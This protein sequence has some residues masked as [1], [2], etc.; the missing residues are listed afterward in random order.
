M[1]TVKKKKKKKAKSVK[2]LTKG[3]E[4]F[5]KLKNLDEHV[6]FNSSL[7]KIAKLQDKKGKS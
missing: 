2:E 5:A 6:D 3:Y 7:K 1:T 4:E